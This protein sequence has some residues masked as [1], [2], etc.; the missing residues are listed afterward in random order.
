M[1]LP[2]TIDLGDLS[3]FSGGPPTGP[4][5]LGTVPSRMLMQQLYDAGE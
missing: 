4:G 3:A 1:D 5:T 2:A